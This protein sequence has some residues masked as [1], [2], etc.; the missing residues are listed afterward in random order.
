MERAAFNKSAGDRSEGGSARD[1]MPNV[2]GHLDIWQYGVSMHRWGA[3]GREPPWRAAADQQS[4]K[5]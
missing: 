2:M 4:F 3:C 5:G 1:F